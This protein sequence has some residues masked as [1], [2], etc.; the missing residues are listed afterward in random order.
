M[1]ESPQA[2]KQT[3][4]D[5]LIE[6]VRQEEKHRWGVVQEWIG[7]NQE[8]IEKNSWPWELTRRSEIFREECN[9]LRQKIYGWLEDTSDANDLYDPDEDLHP[10]AFAWGLDRVPMPLSPIIFLEYEADFSTLINAIAA[11]IEENDWKVKARDVVNC[12]GKSDEWT[13]FP[14]I[15]YHIKKFG[16]ERQS[17]NVYRFY[18]NYAE[19]AVE[20]PEGENIEKFLFE[21][22]KQLPNNCYEIAVEYQNSIIR[23][24]PE[25][26]IHNLLDVD[27]EIFKNIEDA[28]SKAYGVTIEGNKYWKSHKKD[29]FLKQQLEAFD[30]KSGVK[31]IED[32]QIN[33]SN[34]S[35]QAGSAKEKIQALE[36][37]AKMRR[38]KIQYAQKFIY[39]GPW[40]R[41]R[42]KD[43]LE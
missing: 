29:E 37:A 14:P 30:V 19:V 42:I 5:S 13:G 6:R 40:L 23:F 2:R 41:I 12:L 1:S 24:L 21:F 27:L 26:D 20:A 34:I 11:R 28:A 25:Q 43:Q 10:F 16:P 18:Q 35:R 32:T 8:F 39:N 36:Y 38:K 17:K 33:S 22:E 3:I 15:L 7:K 9:S 4:T 31:K